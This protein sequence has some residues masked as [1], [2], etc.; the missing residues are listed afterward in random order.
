MSDLA[1]EKE[2]VRQFI[3]EVWNK[4]DLDALPRFWTA[5][6]VNH[7]LPPG[8]DTG[9][10]AVRA[11]HEPFFTGFTQIQVEIHDQIAEGDKVSTYITFS[12]IHSGEY[13]GIAATG[14]EARIQGFRLD[15]IAG[16]KIAEHRA[17]YDLAGLHE[18]LKS[19]QETTMARD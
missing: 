9:L 7:L 4:A 16:D 10:A 2:V 11:S 3:E 17:V 5:D 19:H 6:C 18:Q 13:R 8:K 12:G 1:A 15:R 14:A